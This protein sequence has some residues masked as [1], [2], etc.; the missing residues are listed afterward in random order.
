MNRLLPFVALLTFGA[1]TRG[2]PVESPRTATAAPE[3]R[4]FR[5][6]WEA[7]ASG[8]VASSR[9]R[10]LMLQRE[11]GAITITREIQPV[12]GYAP[13]NTADLV[14][15]VQHRLAR[16][17]RVVNGLDMRLDA[18]DLTLRGQV[19]SREGAGEIVR[20][21][22]ATPGVDRVISRLTWISAR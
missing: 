19:T 10:G 1:C 18:G 16:T 8:K 4:A 3:Q 14:A 15:R 12:A 20:E 9:A 11:D 7:V 21:A 2:T 13:I 17:E 5:K 22:I 6:A